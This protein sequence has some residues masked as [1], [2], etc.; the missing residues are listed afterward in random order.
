MSPRAMHNRS[1]D[2]P[3]NGLPLSH[4][5]VAAPFWQSLDHPPPTAERAADCTLLTERE[6][7]LDSRFAYLFMELACVLG[8]WLLAAGSF[9]WRLLASK[10]FLLPAIALY[11]LWTVLDVLAVRFR[12]WW[13]PL[14]GSIPIRL[15]G[16][17]LEEHVF[18][19]L[20]TI[21]TMML[22]SLLLETER[23]EPE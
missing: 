18:L 2:R 7:I 12:I 19:I 4:A 3:L 5:V 22:L 17:P 13:F 10:R 14:E 15:L 21:L 6:A 16:L 1:R 23:A 9:S 8:V 20:H 11:A